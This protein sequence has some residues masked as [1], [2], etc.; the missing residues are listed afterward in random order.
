MKSSSHISST[1]RGPQGRQRKRVVERRDSVTIKPTSLQGQLAS[2][3]CLVDVVHLTAVRVALA[4]LPD[5]ESITP[6]AELLTLLSNPTR[7][8]M[9]LALQP[10]VEPRAELCVC[11]L[12]TVCR[13]SKSLT[14]HQLRLLRASGLVRQ[15][16]A[17]RLMFYRLADGPLLSL[18]VDIA[19]L[20][21]RER[22]ADLETVVRRPARSAGRGGIRD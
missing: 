20:A 5:D 4:A 16:R 21:G 13:A 12:A 8:R 3:R 18:L 9:L 2:D 17:G 19:R 14:S 11:D 15:R 1:R 10:G 7:L 6:V 22:A